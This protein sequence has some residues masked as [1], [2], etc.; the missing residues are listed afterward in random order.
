[1][2]IEL[3]EQ[4]HRGDIREFARRTYDNV[5]LQGIAIGTIVPLAAYCSNT[6]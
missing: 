4:L 3:P 6:E 2:S 5:S 1:V